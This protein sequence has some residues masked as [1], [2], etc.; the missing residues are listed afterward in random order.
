MADGWLLEAFCL[1]FTAGYALKAGQ[2]KRFDAHKANARSLE[3]C[4]RE[5]FGAKRQQTPYAVRR[6]AVITHAPYDQVRYYASIKR[7]RHDPDRKPRIT[8]FCRGEAGRVFCNKERFTARLARQWKIIES[9]MEKSLLN[10]KLNAKNVHWLV[11]ANIIESSMERSLL[12]GKFK[13]K[14]QEEKI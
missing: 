7:L 14:N 2:Y 4:S 5:E 3:C 10:G 12:N 1:L 8:R 6:V 13:A 11:N 9:S